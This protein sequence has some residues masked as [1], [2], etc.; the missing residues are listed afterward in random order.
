MHSERHD[1]SFDEQGN[2]RF[3]EGEDE[4]VERVS[5]FLLTHRGEDPDNPDF[6][7]DFRAYRERPEAEW[8]LIRRDVITKVTAIAGVKMVD[9]LEL[10]IDAKT[11]NFVF[12]MRITT[13]TDSQIDLIV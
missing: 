2:L 9:R 3:A 7:V 10:S 11:R 4:I 13:E 12:D 6:G 8:S 1:L 5:T